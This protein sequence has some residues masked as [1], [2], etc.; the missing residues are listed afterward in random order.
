[1]SDRAH[2]EAALEELEAIDSNEIPADLIDTHEQAITALETLSDRFKKPTETDTQPIAEHDTPDE[3]AENEW[4]DQ[5]AEAH[6]KA[7]IPASKGTLTTKT[8]DGRDYYY[9]QWREGDTVTSQYVGP[10]DPA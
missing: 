4:D 8:I 7:D 9:L 3:W 1:M 2:A 5:L 10:V 6:E